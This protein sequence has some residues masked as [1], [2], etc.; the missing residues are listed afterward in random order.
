MIAMIMTFHL[1]S[2]SQIFMW[3]DHNK[4]DILSFHSILQA[5]MIW[6]SGSNN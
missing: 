4:L 3:S 5:S 6:E 1:Q 2:A